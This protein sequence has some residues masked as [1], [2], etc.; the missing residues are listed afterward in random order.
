MPATYVLEP[1][2]ADDANR[3]QRL[4]NFL[5]ILAV[6]STIIPN[7]ESM[8]MD[9]FQS[10]INLNLD[11]YIQAVRSSLKTSAIC[12]NQSP[13][14]VRVNNYNVVDA[15]KLGEKTWTIRSF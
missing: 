5:Y 15:T 13:N 6:L 12:L 11:S 2:D 1:L 10:Q 14:E 8:S 7:H 9:E 3:K 4:K